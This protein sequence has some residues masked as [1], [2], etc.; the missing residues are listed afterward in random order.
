MSTPKVSLVI[1]NYNHAKVLPRALD[2]ALS[3]TVPADEVL[4]VDDGSTDDS[5]EVIA[6]FASRSSRVRS[7]PNER[8]L[9]IGPTCNRGLELAI[10]D[11]VA[12]LASDDRVLPGLVEGCLPLLSAHP[13]AGATSGLCEWRCEATGLTWYQGSRMPTEPVYLPPDRMI[14]LARA[15]RF[16]LAGQHA[17]FKR[18]AVLEAGGW[19]AELRW[20]MDVFTSWVV[21]FRYGVCHVPKVLSV[22]HTAPTSYY[23]S[24]KSAGERGRVL[25]R[26]LELLES[27]KYR[28]AAPAIRA[29]G[30]IGGLGGFALRVALRDRRFWPYLTPGFLAQTTRRTAEVLGRRYLPEPATRLAA[31]LLY[32]HRTQDGNPTPPRNASH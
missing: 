18:S 8:N 30:L 15:G 14:R 20:F 16:S 27:P 31:R 29:S 10:G 24:A 19:L 22:F 17:L 7:C 23:H 13:E 12:F 9:G 6:G 28:D 26:F 1:I 11:Y 21:G 4:V 32:G 25:T 5:R 3:Q 2:A